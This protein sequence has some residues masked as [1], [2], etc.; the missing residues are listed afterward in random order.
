MKCNRQLSYT[1]NI[2]VKYLVQSWAWKLFTAGS[3]ISIFSIP[4]NEQISEYA[5]F[6]YYIHVL[7]FI[8]VTIVLYFLWLSCF[9][10]YNI[11]LT[12]L[13]NYYAYY[14]SHIYI[15]F[16]RD[17]AYYTAVGY[18]CLCEGKPSLSNFF[19]LFNSFYHMV[20]RSSEVS[21]SKFNDINMENV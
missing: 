19:H 16:L 10:D 2:G 4:I 14:A 1:R 15:C 13:Y 5:Y 9:N 6:C 17:E 7:N 11:L 12:I 3:I 8:I 21:L 18:V 20:G